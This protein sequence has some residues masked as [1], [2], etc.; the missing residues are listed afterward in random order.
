MVSVGVMAFSLFLV[1]QFPYDPRK[2][3]SGVAGEQFIMYSDPP[4]AKIKMLNFEGE[5]DDGI[6]ETNK[7]VLTV[8][9]FLPEETPAPDDW[10][11]D[12]RLT[13]DG[14]EDRELTISKAKTRENVYPPISEPVTSLNMGLAAYPEYLLNYRPLPAGLLLFGIL[15]CALSLYLIQDERRKRRVL[16]QVE[17]DPTKDPYIGYNFKSYFVIEKLGKGTSGVVYKVLNKETLDEKKPLALKILDYEDYIANKQQDAEEELQRVKDRFLREMESLA[18]AKHDNIYKIHDFGRETTFDWIVMDYF[19][20][21]LADVIARRPSQGEALRLCRELAAGLQYAHE[22]KIAHR[23]LKPENIMLKDGTL[24]II[25]FGLAKVHDQ[26]DITQTGNIMGTPRYIAPEQLTGSSETCV[27]QFAY[28]LIC[29]ELFTGTYPNT[30]PASVNELMQL[31]LMEKSTPLR[32]VDP[33]QSEELEKVLAKILE[34]DPAKRYP[35]V[36][37]AYLAIEKAVT[38]TKI[39]LPA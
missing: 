33:N 32:Q 20:E 27:D 37:E 24:K 10:S 30:I 9:D 8:N 26:R 25:D 3:I 19:D 35:D 1:H 34:I 22:R 16:L 21:T 12:V 7:T 23:D 39:E 18:D 4:G 6:G 36:W 17:A 15:G 14:C 29:F 38:A 13:K 5:A 2:N 31:R 11:F 28:G